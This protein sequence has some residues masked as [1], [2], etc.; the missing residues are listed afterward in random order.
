MVTLIRFELQ[1]VW[2]K[3][4]FL[5]LMAL[6]L[7]LNVF[8]LWYLN[9]PTGDEPPLCAYKAVCQDISGMTEDEKFTYINDLKEQADG[10]SLVEQVQSLYS[11]GSESGDSLAQQLQDS[12]SDIYKKC[13]ELYRTGDY[14]IY[15]D[16]LAKERILLD[17]LFEEISAVPGYE[18]YLASVQENSN[19]LGGISIFQSSTSKET[20]GTRN[21]AKS[22]AD[23]AE[24]SSADIRWFPSKGITMAVES[25]AT[26]LLLLL[27]VFLFV[28]QLI[29]EEK[30]KGLFAITRSTK[31][32]LFADMG[33]RIVAILI[34]SG[35]VCLLLYG[36]NL[37]YAS[38]MAGI[39]NLSVSLQS[40]A[41]YMES[42]FPISLA[43]FLALSLMTKI[44]VVFL[45]G[46][47][48]T[49]CAVYSSHSFMPQLV[50]IGFLSLNWI[51]YTFIP[52]H[53]S[54]N[55][56]KYLSYFSL[57]R[58]DSLYGTYLNLNI[59]GFPFSRTSC[60]LVLLVILL[61]VGIAAVL[62]LFRY[63]DRLSVNQASV[64]FHVLF[65][66][67]NSLFRHEG[68]KIFIA[69]RGLLILLAFSIFLGS[70]VFEKNYTPSAGEQYYQSMMLSLEGEL[71]EEKKVSIKAE[72]AR[73]D[74]AFIQIERIDQ[75]VAEGSISENDGDS[76]KEPWYSELAFYPWFQRIQTQ[77]ERILSD[78]GVFIYDTGYLYL[79]GQM[80]DDFLINLL[81][82]SL[83]FS[84]AFA[85]VMAME[86][87]KGLW[88]LLSATKLGKKQIVGYK[89][90]ICGVACVGITLLPWFFRSLSISSVYPMGE[91]WAGI[92][93]IPQ[94]Q[95]FPVN[96]PLLLFLMLAVLSQLIST[97]LLCSVVLLISKWRKN[98]FQTLFLALL[99][100]ATPLILAQ[101]GLNVMRWFSVWPLYGWTGIIG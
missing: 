99:L 59:M 71:T 42:S 83:C 20:F 30:E 38:S 78:G 26:D 88:G 93:N 101:M 90:M 29:A 96:L 18:D 33:A 10:L 24:M 11:Q 44:G 85:N 9:Q 95:G 47:L 54:L 92:Q 64:Y 17:E 8:L 3:R 28:G 22:A 80:D 100:L 84:F 19:Q 41:P 79:L 37:I 49:A 98:Y 87:S 32:G 61:S 45:L 74:D 62:L 57:L 14:L 81:L 46:L 94:Y 34:H 91:I 25:Q 52:S 13:E 55:L 67:H 23:H 1:K 73:Y 58:T 27:S 4:S 6:L 68:Y 48:L 35:T 72:Q 66:P 97:Q 39:G 21:I 77:Y 70:N 75:M 31:R 40:L 5:S 12:N 89:W 60:S 2:L 51:L 15:T 56:L 65:H 16:S 76:M 63:G 82:L 69:N 7:L 86:D 53:S 36:S 43:T 50:G